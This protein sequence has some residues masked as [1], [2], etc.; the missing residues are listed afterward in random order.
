M[1]TRHTVAVLA[2]DLAAG[3]TTSR[4]LIEQALARIADLGGRG[5]ACL[6]Q[7]L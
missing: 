4:Q 2:A 6:R 3:R 1:N 5:Q 7:S